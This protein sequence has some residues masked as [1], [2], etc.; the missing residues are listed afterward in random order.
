MTGAPLYCSTAAHFQ[1]YLKTPP[2]LTQLTF[3]GR[4]RRSLL[5]RFRLSKISHVGIVVRAGRDDQV[6]DQ[7]Q[8]PLRGSQLHRP[9]PEAGH[10]TRS[11]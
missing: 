2:V 1:S 8:L 9:E 6:P 10:A 3:K 5:L 4:A 7:R 11:P